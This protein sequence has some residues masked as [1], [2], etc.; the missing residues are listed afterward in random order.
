MTETP[1]ESGSTEEGLRVVWRRW[2]SILKA[3]IFEPHP[4]GYVVKRD[5]V[6]KA[7]RQEVRLLGEPHVARGSSRA[8][9]HGV[10]GRVQGTMGRDRPGRIVAV[11]SVIP[12][13][14]DFILWGIRRV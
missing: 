12:A 3:G 10:C 2:P 6:A 7:W 9:P 1:Q 13:N 14:L 8:A 4:T 5:D 11:L